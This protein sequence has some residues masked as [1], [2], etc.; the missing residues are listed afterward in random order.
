MN[1][2]NCDKCERC[3]KCVGGCSDPYH[4]RAGEELCWCSDDD[5]PTCDK[6]GKPKCPTTG[7][8]SWVGESPYCSGCFGSCQ[9]T[10]DRC[11]GTGVCYSKLGDD[12]YWNCPDCSPKEGKCSP[13]GSCDGSGVVPCPR[14][15]PPTEQEGKWKYLSSS[16]RHPKNKEYNNQKHI[17]PTLQMSVL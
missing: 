4:E 2:R 6:C 3:G 11:G 14:C 15:Q 7:L 10:C 8:K 17:L 13:T 9:P 5:Q 12:T 1:N 16:N